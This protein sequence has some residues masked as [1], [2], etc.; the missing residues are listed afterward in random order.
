MR[1]VLHQPSTCTVLTELRNQDGVKAIV[2]FAGLPSTSK[3]TK[4]LPP[5]MPP[6]V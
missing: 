1:A 4:V 5:L 2:N 3:E 6:E